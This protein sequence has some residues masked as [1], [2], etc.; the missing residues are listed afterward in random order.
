MKVDDFGVNKVLVDRGTTINLMPHSLLRKIGKFDTDLIPY[1]MVL[2]NYEDKT[3]H[4]L[5][6]IQ[7]DLVVRTTI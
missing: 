2:S 4:S 5:G 1:N 3:D 7:V 6:A